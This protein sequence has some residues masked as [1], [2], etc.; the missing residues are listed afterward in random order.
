MYDCGGDGCV[1][2]GEKVGEGEGWTRCG[3]LVGVGI[4]TGAG[5]D[6]GPLV[7][8]G[9]GPWVGVGLDLDPGV[10]LGLGPCVGVGGRPSVGYHA[11]QKLS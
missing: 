6:D 11:D 4:G 2:M 1:G 9:L 8:W 3:P 5:L 10:G 7:G